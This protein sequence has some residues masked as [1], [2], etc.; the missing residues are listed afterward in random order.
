MLARA[1]PFGLWLVFG[2]L[3]SHFYCES[4]QN[5]TNKTLTLL[6]V[7]RL[8]LGNWFYSILCKAKRYYGRDEMENEQ[9]LTEDNAGSEEKGTA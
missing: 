8:L 1:L 6:S 3:L 5:C 7:C 4:K 2:L 9:L